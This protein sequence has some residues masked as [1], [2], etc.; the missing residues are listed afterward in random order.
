M[1]SA[2][3]L[4]GKS[5][6]SAGVILLLFVSYQLWGTG[7]AQARDQ[8][9]LQASLDGALVLPTTPAVSTPAPPPDLGDAVALI[10]I[11]RIAVRQAVVEGVAVEDLKKGP[12]RYPDTK[13]PGE[14]GNA[15]IAGHRTTYGAPFFRLNELGAGDTITVSTR[16]GRFEYRVSESKIVTPN[17]VEVLDDTEDARLTLTTCNPRYSAA[18]R[19]IVVASLV[20]SPIDAPPGAPTP[21]DDPE[22]TPERSQTLAEAEEA[23]LSGSAAAKG[24][25]LYTGLL[26]ALVW[27]ATWLVARSWRRPWLAYALGAPVF[28]VVLFVFFENVAL[29]LPAN[30]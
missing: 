19:L 12:G 30:I 11:P 5:L 21:E 13:M 6:I 9:A 4:F 17:A 25:A 23:G 18:E 24:P 22:A 8:E 27:M 7:V 3:R 26:A 20:G 10:E 29:L 15:A 2:L 14:K 16:S 28:F 1:R